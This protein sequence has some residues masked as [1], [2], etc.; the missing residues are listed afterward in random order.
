MKKIYLLFANLLIVSGFIFTSCSNSDE[1]VQE[2]NPANLKT[3]KYSLSDCPDCLD[4]PGLFD[5]YKNITRSISETPQDYTNF[6]FSSS[7]LLNIEGKDGNV[8][9]LPTTEPNNEEEYLIGV[10]SNK[11]LAYILYCKK[12][13]SNEYTLYNENKEPLFTASYDVE[14][15]LAIVTQVYGNDVPT[16]PVSRVRGGWFTAACSVA[17]SAGCYGLSAIGAV[18]SGGASLGLAACSTMIC[19]ALC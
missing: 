3:E 2:P 4:V 15:K 19:L 6:D 10:G 7:F 11:E 5:G 9:I 17:I 8:Y 18:P 12:S 13:N 16:I 1:E 14:N